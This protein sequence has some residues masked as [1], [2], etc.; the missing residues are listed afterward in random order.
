MK[1]PTKTFGSTILNSLN[2]YKITSYRLKL[3]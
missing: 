2:L 1:M 3:E